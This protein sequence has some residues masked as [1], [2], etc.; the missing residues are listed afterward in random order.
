MLKKICDG[1]AWINGA[2]AVLMACCL[3]S[4]SMIPTGILAINMLVFC[5]LYLIERRFCNDD[6]EE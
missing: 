3:D 4:K 1:F 2:C 6:E 5:T